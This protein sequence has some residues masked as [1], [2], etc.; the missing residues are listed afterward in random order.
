[1][2]RIATFSAVATAF[3]VVAVG[4]DSSSHPAGPDV[5]AAALSVAAAA[6]CQPT[7]F[8]ST[9][10]LYVNQSVSGQTIDLGA[11]GCTYAIYFDGDAPDGAFVRNVTVLQNSGANVGGGGVYNRGADVTVSGSTFETDVTG[12]YVPVRFDSGAQGVISG[13]EITGTHR[14]GIL[15]R[16]AGTDA[17]VSGNTVVAS[18]PKTSG[19]AENG[20]QID[21]QATASVVDNTFA[22][23]W[24][25]GGGNWA[26]TALMVF[27]ADVSV[28]NNTFVDNEFSILVF[29]DGNTVTSNTTSSAVLSDTY[30]AYGVLLFGND[31]H[32]AGNRI[33]ATG[34]AAVGL[35]I[36]AGSGPNRVTGNRFSGFE[37]EIYDGGDGTMI[38]GKP[39]PVY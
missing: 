21:Q 20:L 11:A 28:T 13:N 19:W 17:R 5:S 32:L 27:S 12:Q 18:G 16:G 4:C 7:G 34:D 8:E 23:H 30:A 6:T 38:R 9:T 14:S 35:Y 2:V 26:S 37:D 36:Y 15:I 24:W 22:G 29:G 33:T 10:A 3:A 31:N 1:M 39:T 25:D